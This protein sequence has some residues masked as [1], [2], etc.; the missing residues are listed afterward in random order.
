MNFFSLLIKE[1]H[2]FSGLQI[3]YD[4]SEKEVNRIHT[5]GTEGVCN[6]C[7]QHGALQDFSS[8]DGV[9]EIFI[10]GLCSARC[11]ELASRRVRDNEEF[12]V[13]GHF[14]ESKITLYPMPDTLNTLRLPPKENK[15]DSPV[16]VKVDTVLPLQSEYRVCMACGK[17]GKLWL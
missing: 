16:D 9:R 8:H 3:T 14:D 17:C 10:A 1:I 2:L 13:V 4:G 6:W 11:F 7:K 12:S 15:N 5:S